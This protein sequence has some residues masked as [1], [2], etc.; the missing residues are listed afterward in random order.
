MKG[1]RYRLES[2]LGYRKFQEDDA[3]AALFQ[4]QGV[5]ESERQCLAM[6]EG[7]ARS[8]WARLQHEPGGVI[9]VDAA[10]RAL[11]DLSAMAREVAGQEARVQAAGREVEEKQA[12]LT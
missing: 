4:A 11:V 1:F 3:Q 10:Q 9:D 8:V 2:V 12:A 7:Q 6:L 5:Y